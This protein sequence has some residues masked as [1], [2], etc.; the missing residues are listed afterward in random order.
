MDSRTAKN[1][2]RTTLKPGSVF[3]QGNPDGNNLM[4]Q[5]IVVKYRLINLA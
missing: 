1:C 3:L 4:K 5:A 2:Q